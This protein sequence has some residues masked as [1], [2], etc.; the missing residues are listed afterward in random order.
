MYG[1][2]LPA[3]ARQ[4]PR[5]LN[6]LTLLVA[7]FAAIALA[8]VVLLSIDSQPLKG[9]FSGIL[10]G[11]GT[12][13]VSGSPLWPDLRCMG[14]ATPSADSQTL[15]VALLSFGVISMVLTPLGVVAAMLT[16]F[17]TRAASPSPFPQAP[18]L[19]T[20]GVNPA[21]FAGQPSAAGA[22][23]QVMAA[24]T[25]VIDGKV[26]T[27]LN[28]V[29]PELRQQMQQA[30][31]M[32]GDANNDGIPDILQGTLPMAGL[33]TTPTEASD[34]AERLRKLEELRKAG[35]ITEQEYQVRR[36]QILGEV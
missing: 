1:T 8:F 15:V 29:P 21:S 22:P 32:L 23:P 10:C 14:G 28:D 12:L 3:P 20:T 31:S 9:I 13:D 11:G 25:Y 5:R 6:V 26:Y 19:P 16:V 17:P 34:P 30:M 27:N 33:S 35:L 7:E 18:T 2:G 36:A 4:Q 24:Q